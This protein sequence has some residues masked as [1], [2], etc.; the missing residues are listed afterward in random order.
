MKYRYAK[1]MQVLLF[2]LMIGMAVSLIDAN[3]VE[4]EGHN[5]ELPAID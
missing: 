2:T 1:S 5:I 3:A 4:T